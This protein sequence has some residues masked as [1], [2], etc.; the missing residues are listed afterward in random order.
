[1]AGGG[2]RAAPRHPF[3]SRPVLLLAF[4]FSVMADPVSSVA[5]AIEAA[6]RALGGD[7]AL[8]LPTMGLVV[9]I[10][11]LVITN[12]AQLVGRFPEGGGA[13]AASGAAFG[14]GWAFVPIGALIVDFVLTIAISVSA[15]AS[16]AIAFLPALAPWRVAVALAVLLAVGALTLVGHLGRALFAVM[17]LLF[18]ALCAVVIGAGLQATPLDSAAVGT[19][20]G[21]GAGVAVLLAFPVAMALATGVEAPA[22]AIAELDELDDDGRRLF[23]RFTLFTTLGIVGCLTIGLTAVA[24]RLG[25]GIPDDGSTLVA[26]I[27]RASAGGALYGP[28]QLFTA[29]LLLSATSS[30]LQAGPG[31]LKALA[32]HEH[33]DG[34]STG[35]LPPALGVTN[36]MHTP[37][38]AVL[39]FVLLAGSVV[40]AADGRDQVLVLFYAV[41]VFL[42]FLMGLAAMV[43][44]SREEG[45]V[46]S[47]VMNA[48]GVV[49]VAFTLAV[50]LLRVLPLVSLA[51]A[52][53]ISL[54][55]YAGWVR[56]GRPHGIARAATVGARRQPGRRSASAA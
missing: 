11:A 6:L 26:D 56:A 40:V 29:L 53:I 48:V 39:V 15:A 37:Y 36:A 14:E 21:H 28:F 22:S 16:A 10:I 1:M 42:G 30:S 47:L 13:A 41:A 35:I 17:T 25:I 38:W 4:A 18:V 43:K 7:L 51:A 33:E 31:L 49:L 12:Y 55:L 54:G 23:G 27:A 3:T 9:A 45:R 34:S 2:A 46:P 44:L 50:N 19:G 20:A 5:Y 32:R 8:L 24:V 52:G